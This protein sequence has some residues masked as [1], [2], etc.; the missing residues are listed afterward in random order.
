MKIDD[1]Y[2]VRGLLGSGGMSEV[3]RAWDSLLKQDVAIKIARGSGVTAL[4]REA[5]ALR[6]IDHPGVPRFIDV[7]HDADG[8]W[9]VMELVSGE[10]L[11]AMVERSVLSETEF[12]MFATQLLD[13]IRA[14]HRV[15]VLHLDLKPQNVFVERMPDVGLRG[16]LL[17]FGIATIEPAEAEN[18]EPPVM[19][20]LFFMAPERFDRQPVDC[21]TDLYSAGCVFYFSL[22][23]Q[24]PFQGDVAAQVMVAHLRHIR[25]PLSELRPDIHPA[26]AGWIEW[27]MDRKPENRPASAKEALDDFRKRLG[28]RD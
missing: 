11:D 10:S 2:E 17:D 28:E 23:G 3:H 27:L 15:G 9:L 18:S 20:S 16:K 25:R 12:V 21:R 22:A 26:I 5:A 24:H 7:R 6:R 8:A 4:L 19:G 13:T 14:A 1:R